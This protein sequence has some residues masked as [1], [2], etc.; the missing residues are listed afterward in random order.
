M[1]NFADRMG[2]GALMV[3]DL[4]LVEYFAQLDRVAQQCSAAPVWAVVPF[5]DRRDL[6]RK[7]RAS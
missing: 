3:I 6:A 5:I 4:A 1:L 2:Y 7:R